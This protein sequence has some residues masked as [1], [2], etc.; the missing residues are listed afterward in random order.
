M[1]DSLTLYV[2]NNLALPCAFSPLFAKFSSGD[3]NCVSRENLEGFTRFDFVAWWYRCETVKCTRMRIKILERIIVLVEE[4]VVDDTSDWLDVRATT[5]GIL[6]S[7][8][9]HPALAP[10]TSRDFSWSLFFRSWN[11][12]ELEFSRSISSWE[13]PSECG[14]LNSREILG[15]G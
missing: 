4:E 11:P 2:A 10:P 13:M 7:T 6:R 9:T 12:L 1:E 8:R 14:F 5:D 15:R 3:K